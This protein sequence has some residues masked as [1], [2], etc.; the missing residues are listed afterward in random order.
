MSGFQITSR[1]KTSEDGNEG[2]GNVVDSSYDDDSQHC[3][4]W[5]D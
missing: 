2:A 1:G 3:T 4:T 5:K